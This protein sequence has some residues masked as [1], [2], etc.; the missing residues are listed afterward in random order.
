MKKLMYGAALLVV[1]AGSVAFLPKQGEPT[2]YMLVSG[3]Y[4]IGSAGNLIVVSATEQITTE[5]STKGRVAMH[6]AEMDKLGQLRANG[7]VVTQMTQSTP[8]VGGG[9]TSYLLE[10]R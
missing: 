5:I 3:H 7:W 9:I 2:G 10:K 1:A 4:Y 8:A 6:Q